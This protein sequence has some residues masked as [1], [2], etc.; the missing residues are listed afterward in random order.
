MFYNSD[1]H[2]LYNI[3]KDL[4]N[5]DIRHIEKLW[6]QY[7]NTFNHEIMLQNKIVN[8]MIHNYNH[9]TKTISSNKYNDINFHV[10]NDN[11]YQFDIKYISKS[12]LIKIYNNWKPGNKSP[13]IIN[14]TSIYIYYDDKAEFVQY[15][16]YCEILFM[17]NLI[18][19]CQKNYIIKELNNTNYI[20]INTC[21]QKIM[22][23]TSST[24]LTD[25]NSDILEFKKN[26]IVKDDNNK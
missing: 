18:M 1:I 25:Y 17:I 11:K 19:K 14:D 3:V 23:K 5:K 16:S 10:P 26:S 22:E 8:S 20:D 21:L 7:K 24:S 4:N 15:E 12:Q 13:Y 9:K 6:I 2:L